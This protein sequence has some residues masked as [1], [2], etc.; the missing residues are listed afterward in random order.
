MLD[1]VHEWSS[2]YKKWEDQF[3]DTCKFSSHELVDQPVGFFV[4]LSSGDDN[5][6][7]QIYYLNKVRAGIELYKNKTYD[8]EY[9]NIYLVLHDKENGVSNDV[10]TLRIEKLKKKFVKG[11]HVCELISMT[12]SPKEEDVS[13]NFKYFNKF[14]I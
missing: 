5:L 4:L 11:N 12:F 2:W 6:E 1:P 10:A 13:F 8:N 3:L 9:P 14:A 7:D